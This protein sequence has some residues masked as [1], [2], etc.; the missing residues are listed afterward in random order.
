MGVR[1]ACLMISDIGNNCTT[2]IVQYLP[3]IIPAL[4]TLLNNPK[5]EQEAHIHA[6]IAMGDACLASE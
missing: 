4:Q 1:V 5:A 3:K 6:I 2:E